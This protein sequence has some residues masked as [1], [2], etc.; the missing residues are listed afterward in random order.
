MV[1]PFTAT[2]PFVL[3]P[4]AAM[5]AVIPMPTPVFQINGSAYIHRLA[6]VNG[7]VY[8][9]T[10]RARFVVAVAGIGT[11]GGADRS[12]QCSTDDRG[13]TPAD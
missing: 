3:S 13:I 9:Y 5:P 12:S 8:Y 6:H 1:V 10:L 11:D 7:L 4:M 2:L